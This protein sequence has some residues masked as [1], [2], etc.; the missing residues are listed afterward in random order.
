MKYRPKSSKIKYQYDMIHGL[1][2]Y[3]EEELEPLE[4]VKEEVVKLRIL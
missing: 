2:K 3:L 1:R 4:Y